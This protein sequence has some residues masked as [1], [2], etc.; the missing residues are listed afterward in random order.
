MAAL[1]DHFESRLGRLIGAWSASEQSPE[2]SP[3]VGY[4]AGGALEGVQSYATIGLHNRHLT[5]RTSSRAQHLEL[6]GC[7][8]PV[9]GEKYGPFP[10]VLEFVAEHLVVSEEA[11]LRGEVIPL[12]RPLTPE[13]S[14]TALYAAVPVYF[15]DDFASVALENKTDVSIVWLVPIS[16]AERGFVETKGWQAFE[17]ELVRQDPDLLDLSRES[18]ILH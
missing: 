13:G 3:Q 18:M 14:L 4:F 16:D 6:L 5:P 17:S 12:P 1:V 2:G 11:V 15:D 8:R 10:G 9:P 7:N